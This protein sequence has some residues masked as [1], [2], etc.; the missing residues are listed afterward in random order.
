MRCLLGGR[1][2]VRSD[3]DQEPENVYRSRNRMN[4]DEI[5]KTPERESYMEISR[6]SITRNM[7]NHR[8]SLSFRIA[9]FN[10]YV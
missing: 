5:M 6:P 1:I 2:G 3:F 7:G 4:D 10:L 8:E 9:W